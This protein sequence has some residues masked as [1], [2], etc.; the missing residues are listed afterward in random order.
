MSIH[1]VS[2]IVAIAARIAWC[3]LTVIDHNTLWRLSASMS[4]HDQNPE[5]ARNVI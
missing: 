1:T 5:S 2:G 3:W 4:F